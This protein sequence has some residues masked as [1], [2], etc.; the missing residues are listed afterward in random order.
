MTIR[1]SRTAAFAFAI[2]ATAG[3]FAGIGA[4]D[5]EA[6]SGRQ[7][8]VQEYK[9]DKP[10]HGYEGM[11]TG[12]YFCSYVRIPNRKCTYSGGREVCKVKGWILRQECR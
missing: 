1:T 9:T 10:L 8:H 11:A 6:K 5:A 3:L 4:D 7:Y 2:A 12:G